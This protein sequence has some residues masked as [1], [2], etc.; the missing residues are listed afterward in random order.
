VC[1]SAAE[2]CEKEPWFP[3]QFGELLLRKF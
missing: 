3:P 1:S 2:W